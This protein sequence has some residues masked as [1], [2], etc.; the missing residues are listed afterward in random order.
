MTEKGIS[1]E[2]LLKM[3]MGVEPDDPD[4]KHA[5]DIM[6]F[7][8]EWETI[9]TRSLDKHTKRRMMRH[10]LFKIVKRLTRGLEMTPELEAIRAIIEPQF[11]AGRQQNWYSFTFHWDLHPKDHTKII[12]KD[13]WFAEGGDYDE[14][15][16]LRPAAF[17]EQEI[18]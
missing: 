3:A 4:A 14:F 12:T 7:K 11:E 8:A 15:G 17:T 2:Q 10:E 5:N 16:S 9:P 18:S 13:R 6:K 1:D